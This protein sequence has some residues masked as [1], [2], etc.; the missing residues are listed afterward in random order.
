LQFSYGHLAF[1][2]GIILAAAGMAQ[3]VADPKAHLHGVHALLLG[4]GVALYIATFCYTRIVMFGGASYTRVIAS[5]LAIVITVCSPGL[6][7]LAP[8][9]ML[10]ALVI[11]LNCFELYWVSSGRPLLL[12]NIGQGAAGR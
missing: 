9:A 3:A 5:L 2:A 6:P 12:I 10:T 7:A 4:S 8:L 11:A 1:V